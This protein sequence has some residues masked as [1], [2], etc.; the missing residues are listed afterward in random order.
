MIENKIE[1]IKPG[2]KNNPIRKVRENNIKIKIKNSFTSKFKLFL[3]SQILILLTTLYF[4]SSLLIEYE[5]LDILKILLI[6]FF[7]LSII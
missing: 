4:L 5:P 1:R 2:L 6:M 3:L 7:C